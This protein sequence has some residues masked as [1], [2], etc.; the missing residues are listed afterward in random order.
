M[1][2]LLQVTFLDHEISVVAC[3]NGWYEENLAAIKGKQYSAGMTGREL[4]GCD[5]TE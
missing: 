3:C 4:L 1:Q 2:W 5:S